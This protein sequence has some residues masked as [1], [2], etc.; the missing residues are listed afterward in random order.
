MEKVEEG[1][2]GEVIITSNAANALKILRSD[3][4]V[5]LQEA[6]W[7]AK[8]LKGE[9]GYYRIPVSKATAEFYKEH[10]YPPPAWKRTP[11]MDFYVGFKKCY[12]EEYP[13]H[14]GLTIP[15]EVALAWVKTAVP[16][17][18]MGNNVPARDLTVGGYPNTDVNVNG[19]LNKLFIVVD[20]DRSGKAVAIYKYDGD[21]FVCVQR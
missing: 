20:E 15:P 16:E 3:R 14:V 4:D 13:F 5:D 2:E 10:G 9:D 1:V 6:R 18:V 19:W 21:F 11:E 12:I 17:V 7:M 8:S